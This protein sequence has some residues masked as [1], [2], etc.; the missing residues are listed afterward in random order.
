MNYKAL[1]LRTR[2]KTTKIK[3]R[4]GRYAELLNCEF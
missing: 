4:K 1:S 2:K 3:P